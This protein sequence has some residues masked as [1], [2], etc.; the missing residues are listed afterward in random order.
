MR[1][2][3]LFGYSGVKDVSVGGGRI[4]NVKRVK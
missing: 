4:K 2:F 1:R 3:E